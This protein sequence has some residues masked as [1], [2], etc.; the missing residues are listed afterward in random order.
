MVE[1]DDVS[2]FRQFAAECRR[3]A[4]RAAERDKATLMEIAAAWI[5]RAEHVE[6]KEFTKTVSG[7]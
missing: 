7:S 2:R 3:L 1:D 4:E 5:S 6:R